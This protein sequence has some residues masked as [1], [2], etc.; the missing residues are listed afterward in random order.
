MYALT[1]RTAS[2][3]DP[4]HGCKSPRGYK[5]ALSRSG[6]APTA[7]ERFSHLNRFAL[8]LALP[9]RPHSRRAAPVRSLDA[10]LF[11]PIL[12]TTIDILTTP[13]ALS[14]LCAILQHHNAYTISLPPT[15]TPPPHPKSLLVT[16]CIL[17]LAFLPRS[18]T[19][20]HVRSGAHGRC[21]PQPRVLRV[22][23]RL[24]RSRGR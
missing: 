23:P 4:C 11:D 17:H 18:L 24:P 8:A 13:F 6:P 10:R 3:R 14:L 2:T 9:P 15:S 1:G 21:G 20:R 5:L 16:P 19:R 12:L 7:R 22:H